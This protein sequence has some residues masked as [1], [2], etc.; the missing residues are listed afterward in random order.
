MCCGL[1]SSI[2]FRNIEAK[3]NVAF[4]SSPLVV[5]SGGIAKKPR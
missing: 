4:E 5:V 3:P 1:I 2:A